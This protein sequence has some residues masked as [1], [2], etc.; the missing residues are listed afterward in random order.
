MI[1]AMMLYAKGKRCYL[2]RAYTKSVREQIE[3]SYELL[4]D[5]V[6]ETQMEEYAEILQETEALF[7]SWWVPELTEQQIKKYFPKLKILFYAAGSVQY[8]AKP[9]LKQGIRVVSGWMENGTPV[10]EYTAAQIVLANK[11]FFQNQARMRINYDEAREFSDCFSGNYGA[12]IGILGAGAV[13]SHV[14]SLLHHY[15]MDIWVYDPYL[16]EERA[17][18][19]KVTKHGLEEIF[20]CCDVIS[21][22]VAKLPETEG[23]LNY[24]LLSRMKS[25][26]TLLNTGRGSQIVEADLVR[27]MRENT[28]RTAVLDVT[29]P[30]PPAAD[31]LLYGEPNIILTTHIAGSMGLEIGRIGQY[32][33]DEALRFVHG[34]ALKYEIREETLKTMA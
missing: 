17:E 30:E 16:T 1:K 20:E 2:E 13:G 12:K 14:I 15:E 22:H 19:L 29:D 7:T 10:A 21:N 23:M 33:A 9:F 5:P 26:S 11:G 18:E 28:T 27:A 24:A 32:I 25:Y 6:N 4:A 34:D 8:F 31:S 3:A